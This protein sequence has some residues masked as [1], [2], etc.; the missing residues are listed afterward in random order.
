MRLPTHIQATLDWLIQIESF[1]QARSLA[2][3]TVKYLNRNDPEV[4]DFIAMILYRAKYYSEALSWAEETYRIAPDLIAAKYNLARCCFYAGEFVKAEKLIDT[5]L[6]SQPEWLD[7][8]LDK[9]LY[10]CAQGRFEEAENLLLTLQKKFPSDHPHHDVVRFNLA[11]HTLRRGHFK[12]GLSAMTCGRKIRIFGSVAQTYPKPKL[13]AGLPIQGKTILIVGEG[14][15]GDEIINVRFADVAH[16][17]GAKCIWATNQ[18]LEGLFSRVKGLEKVIPVS[19]IAAEDYD[20]W[21]PA[22]DLC[23]LLELEQSELPRA[24]Y[25][26]ADPKTMARWSKKIGSSKRFKVGLRWQGNPLYEQDLHRSV[27]FEM[28]RTFLSVP[29]CDFFSLQRDGGV[30]DIQPSDPLVDLSSELLSWED[31]AAAIM[32]LD[33]IITSCTSV[34]HLAG[35]LGKKVFLFTPTVCYY[36]WAHPGNQSI[37]YSDVKLFRQKTFKDWSFETAEIRKDLERILR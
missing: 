5:V 31:T 24:P 36:I 1:D 12:E 19:D 17:R 4:T 22:M 20:Y 11:W 32:S 7:P 30:E 29:G 16:S 3:T 2:L 10:I 18:N 14:G 13:F 6:R 9:A 34:A 21:A 26:T 35:A 25:L 15:A 27:P 23:A 33:L 28:M 37:W 8:N